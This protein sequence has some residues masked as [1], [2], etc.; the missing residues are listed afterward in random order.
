M[1]FK[2]VVLLRYYSAYLSRAPK[3]YVKQ[4]MSVINA[5]EW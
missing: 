2:I 1:T 3:Y 4:E 5:D